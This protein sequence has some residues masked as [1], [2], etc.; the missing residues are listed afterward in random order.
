ML[1][2]MEHK[3]WLL[4]LLLLASSCVFQAHFEERQKVGYTIRPQLL[5]IHVLY[6]HVYGNV[7]LPCPHARVGLLQYTHTT[8]INII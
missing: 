8:V 2:R 5:G 3:L 1:E 7:N 6:M 4:L